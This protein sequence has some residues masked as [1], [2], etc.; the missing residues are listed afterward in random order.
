V[1]ATGWR[2]VASANYD[3]NVFADPFTFDIGRDPNYHVAFSYG[4]HFCLGAHLAR[5][6]MRIAFEQLLQRF[7]DMELA[8]EV[9]RLA[10]MQFAGIKHMPVRFTP[11][12]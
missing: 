9:E 4:R 1:R 7:P 6:E 12:R 11:T 3:E 10:S 2:C 8:G 5:L